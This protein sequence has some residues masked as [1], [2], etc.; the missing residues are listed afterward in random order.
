[1]RRLSDLFPASEHV[2]NLQLHEQDDS[3]IWDYARLHGFTVVSKDSDFNDRSI[4]FSHPP[5][6]IQV[7]L[8]NCS[9]VAVEKLLRDYFDI[10]VTFEQD[11]SKSCQHL[12]P[13]SWI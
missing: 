11:E 12:P 3:V 8:G 13:Y 6:V 10:L 7:H 1:V 9:S 4:L 5:K 2:F